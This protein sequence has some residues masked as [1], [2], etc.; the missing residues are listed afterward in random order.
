M[1]WTAP[2]TAVTGNEFTAQQYNLY[3]RDNFMMLAP[4]LVTAEGQ[5]VVST[6][7]NET[8]VREAKQAIVTAS[9]TRTS[10][11]YGDLSTVGPDVRVKH[12]KTILVFIAA[13]MQ[14]NTNN[15]QCRMSVASSVGTASVTA[16]DKWCVK[17]D[18]VP[19]GQDCR[20]SAARLIGDL[21]PGTTTFRAKYRVGGGTGTFADRSMAIVP[22]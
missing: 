14:N 2:L 13:T 8:D 7:Q 18:G 19:L 16:E 3:V 6:G 12:G 5:Y 9:E 17:M 21:D 15:F 10:T 22:L 4:Q 1:A 11:S 20:Y